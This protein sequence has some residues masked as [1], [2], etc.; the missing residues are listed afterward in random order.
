MTTTDIEK[1]IKMIPSF[2]HLSLLS[3]DQMIMIANYKNLS[4]MGTKKEL[5]KRLGRQ[6]FSR[7][8]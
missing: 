7:D 2:Y 8:N 3:L 5:T 4:T 1:L 6:M